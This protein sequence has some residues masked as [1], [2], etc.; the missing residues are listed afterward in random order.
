VLEAGEPVL[1]LETGAKR[2]VPLGELTGERLSLAVGALQSLPRTHRR[3]T[4][5]RWGDEPIHGSAG[6]S[7]LQKLGFE[8]TPTGLILYL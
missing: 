3:I 8:R 1:L 2:L 5:T 4:V 6:E 7:V